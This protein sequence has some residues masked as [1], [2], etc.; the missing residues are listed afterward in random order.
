MKFNAYHAPE[1]MAFVLKLPPLCCQ[2]ISLS[3]RARRHPTISAKLYQTLDNAAKLMDKSPAAL[4][5]KPLA[6]DSDVVVA[7]CLSCSLSRLGIEYAIQFYSAPTKT[8]EMQ[9]TPTHTHAGTHTHL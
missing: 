3:I 9:H 7:S 1:G 2:P 8:Y 4:F 6:L 5:G